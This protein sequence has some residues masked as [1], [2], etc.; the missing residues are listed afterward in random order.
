VRD[1]S[2]AAISRTGELAVLLHPS[3]SF[4]LARRGT[5][6]R[7]PE[8]GSAPRALA[9]D[10]EF[11]DWSP[12]GELAFTRVVGR[13][14]VLEFPAGRVLYRTEGWISHL[15][16]SH[17]GDRIAFLHHPVFADDAGEVVVLDTSGQ[18]RTL[19]RRWPRT[20]GLAWSP[21]IRDP[22]TRRCARRSPI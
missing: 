6:A 8:A 5:L 3:F 10:V 14:R 1:A 17:A 22:T 19:G 18:A 4:F 15:R 16:F 2:L 7:V 12:N 20:Y 21:E 13:T 11:A 9:E